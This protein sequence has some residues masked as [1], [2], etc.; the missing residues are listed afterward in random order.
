[1]QIQHADP[2]WHQVRIVMWRWD[3]TING[4]HW[5]FLKHANGLFDHWEYM[6]KI[7]GKAQ[8]AQVGDCHWFTADRADEAHKAVRVETVDGPVLLSTPTRGTSCFPK[9]WCC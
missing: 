1:M 5:I 6:G 8:G 3:W 7:R 9:A 4:E 2:Q